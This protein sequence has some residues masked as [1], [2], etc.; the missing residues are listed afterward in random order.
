MS[1]R[2]TKLPRVFSEISEVENK[3]IAESVTDFIRS[4][5]FELADNYNRATI[6]QKKQE[7]LNWIKEKWLHKI[8]EDVTEQHTD[9]EWIAIKDI[10]NVLS[11]FDNLINE[12]DSHDSEI[13]FQTRRSNEILCRNMSEFSESWEQRYNDMFAIKS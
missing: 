4:M 9:L 1:K 6:I 10:I 11:S 5:L 12:I 8:L 13:E 7:F 3:Y 2:N